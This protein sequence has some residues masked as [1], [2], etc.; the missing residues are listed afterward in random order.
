MYSLKSDEDIASGY[1]ASELNSHGPDRLGWRSSSKNLQN[2]PR[3]II[4]KLSVV[5]EIFKENFHP[6]FFRRSREMHGTMEELKRL[7]LNGVQRREEKKSLKLF[8]SRN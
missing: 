2:V 4:L 7:L 6:F 3:E 5:A 1:P 8:I